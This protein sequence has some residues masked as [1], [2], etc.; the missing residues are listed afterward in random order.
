MLNRWH[1]QR[2]RAESSEVIKQIGFE[3]CKDLVCVCNLKRVE[4]ILMRMQI[5]AQVEA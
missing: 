3:I 5:T 4:M 1:S 2:S